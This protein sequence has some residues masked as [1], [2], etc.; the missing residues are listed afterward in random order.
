MKISK[1]TLSLFVAVAI[2]GCANKM[3]QDG[4]LEQ[5]QKNYNSYKEIV[6]QYKIDTQWWLG[7]Q[8]SQLNQLI[9]TALANNKNLA[10]SAILVN[11]A[12]YNAN[13]LGAN[14]VPTFSATGQSSAV[15]GAGH[16]AKNP[17]ST[18]T[19]VVTHSANLNLSYT[20]DLWQRLSNS[21]SAAEWEKNATAEDLEATRLALINAVINTYY[22]L[23]YFNEAIHITQ[24]SINNYTKISRVMNNKYKSG[25]ITQLNVDQSM[26]AVLQARNSLINLQTAQKT[27]EQTL[28]NLL[29]LKPNDSIPVTYPNLLKVKLQEVNTDVPVSTIANRPDLKSALFRLQSGFKS[30]QATENSWYPTLSLGASLSGSAPL[31]GDIANNQLLGGTLSF[32]LPFLDWNRVKLNIK[33]SEQNYKLAKLNYEQI[34]TKALNEIST[35]YYTYK[36]SKKSLSNLKKTYFYNKRISRYYQNR[37]KEGVS[38]LRDWLNAINT[39]NGSKLAIIQAKYNTLQYENLVYQAMAGKYS[40]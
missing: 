28:R 1:I 12:L 18:G 29:N 11:K 22:N 34:G 26:Q 4:S 7:Y 38:E 24:Q 13:L 31:V 25:M 10:K 36:Q 32:N 40:K 16:S 27:A 5:V 17:R 3:S 9:E 19:S 15:K 21:A 23:A 35:Y 8:D 14:L 33:I 39:E 20:L 6:K 2:T 30:L 37:Y